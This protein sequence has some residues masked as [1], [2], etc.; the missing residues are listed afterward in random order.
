MHQPE[1]K[2]AHEKLCQIKCTINYQFHKE[3]RRKARRVDDYYHST[4][5][6]EECIAKNCRM[7]R[8]QV[9]DTPEVKHAKLLWT[10]CKTGCALHQQQF[11]NAQKVDDY[12][13]STLPANLYKATDCP[14]HESKKPE[15]RERTAKK[16]IPHHNI[17]WSFCYNDQCTNH[18][19]A[20]IGAGRFPKERRKSQKGRLSKPKNQ[21]AA[22]DR[23]TLAK[24]VLKRPLKKCEKQ[25]RKTC[26]YEPQYLQ[27]D[28]RCQRSQI[29]G[30][31]EPS[32]HHEWQKTT[33][34]SIELRKF[35]YEQYQPTTV[36]RHTGTAG[37]NLRPR[38]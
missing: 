36:P 10:H 24:A 8:A 6:A 13:H 7:H 5:S 29:V 26:S 3:Q 32:S 23:V 18:Y 4:I 14:I 15:P 28:T 25:E 31:H 27:T 1:E 9:R 37:F 21:D 35:R 11:K 2:E 38:Q 17:H 12:Y 16:K 20:K 22:R 33:T 19:D 30:Q 34:Y